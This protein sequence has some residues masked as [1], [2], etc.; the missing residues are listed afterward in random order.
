MRAQR[1]N[2]DC[3]CGGS[4]D[5]FVARAPRNDAVRGMGLAHWCPRRSAASL[6]R[7]AAEPGPTRREHDLVA[8]ERRE[9]AHA[10]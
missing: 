8:R 4:L 9:P 2:P 7:Y 1:S 3:F 6:R 10:T 5:C